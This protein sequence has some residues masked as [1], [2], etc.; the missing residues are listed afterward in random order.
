MSNKI[1]RAPFTFLG[2]KIKHYKEFIRPEIEQAIKENKREYFVDIFGG[3]QNTA[4]QVSKDFPELQVKTFNYNELMNYLI[5]CDL[6]ELKEATEELKIE[7]PKLIVPNN[8]KQTRANL[9]KNIKDRLKINLCNVAFSLQGIQKLDEWMQTYKAIKDI[10]KRFSAIYN[11][12]ADVQKLN[13]IYEKFNKDAKFNNAI[14][15][16]D[17]PYINNFNTYIE[18]VRSDNTYNNPEEW[19]MQDDRELVEF[20][21]NNQGTNTFFVWTAKQNHLWYLLNDNFKDAKQINIIK[22]KRIFTKNFITR[23]TLFVIK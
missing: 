12:F 6:K 17:P 8:H 15:N 14:I 16:L 22:H 5:S 4:L 9:I 7:V 18:E 21:K 3:S 10:D 20:I 11:Y 19:L 2:N 23:E 13:P 1:T